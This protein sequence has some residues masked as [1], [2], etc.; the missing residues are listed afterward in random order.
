MNPRYVVRAGDAAPFEWVCVAP[1][2]PGLPATGDAELLARTVADAPVV[3]LMQGDAVRCLQAAIP[4]RSARQAAQAAPFAIEDELAEDIEGLHIVCGPDL[5]RGVRSV[6]I[7]RRTA[8]DELI[9]PLLTAGVRIGAVIPEYFAL[10]FQVDHWSL[11]SRNNVIVARTGQSQ[12]FAIEAETFPAVAQRLAADAPPAGIRCFGAI[13][14]AP[15]FADMTQHEKPSGGHPLAFLGNNLDPQSVLDL[16]PPDYRVRDRAAARRL[17][18]AAAVLLV[19]GLLHFGWLWWTN[20]AFATE[21]V[22]IRSAQA[23]L[24][25]DVFPEITRVVNPLA[26]ATQA[27]AALRAKARPAS[28]MLDTLHRAGRALPES[29]PTFAGINYADGVLNLRV[30]ARDIAALNAYSEALKGT[31]RA[32]V[33]SVDTRDDGVDG[34][35]RVQALPRDEP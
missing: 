4:A 2:A 32:E 34:N 18:A 13:P 10:P 17:W 30:R 23:A 20:H 35:L 15:H 9:K 6:A 26:Q 7:V 19:T 25:Q 33:V 31:L 16:L 5:G 29:G 24:M 28:S 14:L 12:G 21:L 27:V 8:L 11:W 3:V 1:N 22:A